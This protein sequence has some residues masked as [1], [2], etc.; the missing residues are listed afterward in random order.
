MKNDGT[1]EVD[2]TREMYIFRVTDPN[3]EKTFTIPVPMHER[4]AWCDGMLIQD[5]MPSLSKED[6]ELMISGTC[7]ECWAGMEVPEG[8]YDERDWDDT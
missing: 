4:Q 3:C 1:P 5:A 6:R 7:P 8:G 2:D